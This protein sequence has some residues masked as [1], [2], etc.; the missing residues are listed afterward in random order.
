[1]KEYDKS[2]VQKCYHNKNGMCDLDNTQCELCQQFKS[3]DSELRK[4]INSKITQQ[5]NKIGK[6]NPVDKYALDIAFGSMPEGQLP[7][8]NS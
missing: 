4:N 2:L 8:P 3:F 1:M 5:E 7:L 6:Y